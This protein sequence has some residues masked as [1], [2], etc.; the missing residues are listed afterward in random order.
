MTW[1][2]ADLKNLESKQY[3]NITSQVKELK[4]GTVADARRSNFNYYY[5]CD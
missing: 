4:Q 3:F 1:V 5:Y 2:V